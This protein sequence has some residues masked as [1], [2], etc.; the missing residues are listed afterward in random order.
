MRNHWRKFVTRIIKRLW[1]REA[2]GMPLPETE[3]SGTRPG[4]GQ[5]HKPTWTDHTRSHMREGKV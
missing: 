2:G 4:S 5:Q 3:A 1:R